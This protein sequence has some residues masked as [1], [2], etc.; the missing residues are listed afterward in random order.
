MGRIRVLIYFIKLR[1]G[2]NFTGAAIYTISGRFRNMAEQLSKLHRIWPLSVIPERHQ[3]GMTVVLNLRDAKQA[4]SPPDG[5]P[6]RPYD[7]SAI[8][9]RPLSHC[10]AAPS[11]RR[12]FPSDE[13]R[14]FP[15]VRN[16]PQI[17][18]RTGPP[19]GR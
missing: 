6:S 17:F 1:K 13:C 19:Y 4:N 9:Q 10:S 12:K 2:F 18:C 7:R 14:E 16:S 15:T 3:T 5:S 11:P 8:A